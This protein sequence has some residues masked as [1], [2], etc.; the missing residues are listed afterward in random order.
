MT[1]IIIGLYTITLT[2]FFHTEPGIARMPI[3]GILFLHTMAVVYVGI[4]YVRKL[5]YRYYVNRKAYK[6]ICQ[7]YRK[8]RMLCI[9]YDVRTEVSKETRKGFYVGFLE[10]RKIVRLFK[11][12]L[13]VRECGKKDILISFIN[14]L[15]RINTEYQK[16]VEHKEDIHWNKESHDGCMCAMLIAYIVLW[17]LTGRKADV[18]ANTEKFFGHINDIMLYVDHITQNV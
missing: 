12:N 3:T 9:Q 4:L 15:N 14:V 18:K 17:D 1:M 2:V 5:W 8:I 11:N 6:Q 13:S 7:L 10:I 16:N